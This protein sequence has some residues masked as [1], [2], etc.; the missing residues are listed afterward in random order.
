M[1]KVTA[2]LPHPESLGGRLSLQ[3]WGDDLGKGG[4]PQSPPSSGI[5]GVSL[6]YQQFSTEMNILKLRSKEKNNKKYQHV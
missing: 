5:W 1:T 3:P 4:D 2:N 6:M